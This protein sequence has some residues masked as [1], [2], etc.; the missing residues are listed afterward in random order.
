MFSTALAALGAFVGT[1][2]DDFIVLIVLFLASRTG[3]LRLRHIIGGQYAGFAV[4]LLVSLGAAVG[5]MVIPDKWV[6]LLGLLPLA[7]GVRGL[8][9]AARHTDGDEGVVRAGGLLAVAAITIGNGGDNISVYS[10]M[11][12]T[13]G[14]V[15]RLVT[16]ATFLVLL[17]VWCALASVVSRHRRVIAALVRV[18]HWLV[19]VVY[20]V[21][22]G[23]IVL[24]S[25]V[26]LQLAELAR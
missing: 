23:V 16:L 2:I 22:G 21:I 19:P 11:L 9:L 15:D 6:G 10:V 25:G 5:L 3:T 13:L 7:L 12:R 20:V 1:N 18:G 24:R 26:L 14:T 17:G 8:V 4:L